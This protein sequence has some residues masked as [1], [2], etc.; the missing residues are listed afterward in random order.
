[1]QEG[2]QQIRVSP[3]VGYWDSWTDEGGEFV[4]PGEE[5]V[6]GRDPNCTFYQANGN[7]KGGSI[8][9][10]S[11]KYSNNEERQ[12]PLVAAKLIPVPLKKKNHQVYS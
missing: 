7:Y 9:L 10:F 3:E 8:Q 6:K 5:N 2:Y 4:Q 1:M 11:D 12:Q